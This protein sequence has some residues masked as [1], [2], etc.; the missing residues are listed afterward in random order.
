MS[1]W[2]RLFSLT[3]TQQAL[4]IRT[5]AAF[6]PT[7]RALQQLGWMDESGVLTM[8]APSLESLIAAPAVSRIRD[9]G[10]RLAAWRRR[11]PA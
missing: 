3:G 6:Q 5:L 9:N 1:A 8:P 2:E 7:M 4:M 11:E 10:R